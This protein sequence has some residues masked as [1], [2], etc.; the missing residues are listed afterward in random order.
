M[1]RNQWVERIKNGFKTLDIKRVDNEHQ[2]VIRLR[3]L[4][5]R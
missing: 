4:K 3:Y 1:W 2:D 5:K